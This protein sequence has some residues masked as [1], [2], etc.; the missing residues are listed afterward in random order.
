M[1]EYEAFYYFIGASKYSTNSV[2]IW[3]PS[4]KTQKITKGLKILFIIDAIV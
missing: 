4:I 3:Q 2:S 1:E